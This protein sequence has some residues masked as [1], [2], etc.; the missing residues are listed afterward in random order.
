MIKVVGWLDCV[1]IRVFADAWA[2]ACSLQRG[3]VAA[4]VDAD[5]VSG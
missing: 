3:A 5:Q 2:N 1:G 4:A